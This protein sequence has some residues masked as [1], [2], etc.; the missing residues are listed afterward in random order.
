MPN[1]GESKYARINESE[2]DVFNEL[3][4]LLRQVHLSSFRGNNHYQYTRTLLRIFEPKYKYVITLEDMRQAMIMTIEFAVYVSV[5]HSHYATVDLLAAKFNESR[6]LT[7]VCCLSYDKAVNR[8]FFV[9]RFIDITDERVDRIPHQIRI[10]EEKFKLAYRQQNSAAKAIQRGWRK[11]SSDCHA[12]C[13]D[14][15][16][17]CERL[18][19][20]QNPDRFNIHTYWIGQTYIYIQIGKDGHADERGEQVVD[21]GY[22][23]IYIR[24]PNSESIAYELNYGNEQT[25]KNRSNKVHTQY[26][27][28][29]IPARAYICT[30]RGVSYRKIE[31]V[32]RLGRIYRLDGRHE[33]LLLQ[34]IRE[35]TAFFSTQPYGYGLHYECNTFVL[36]SLLRLEMMMQGDAAAPTPSEQA[37][38]ARA[39]NIRD[40]AARDQTARRLSARERKKPCGDSGCNIM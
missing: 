19:V 37:T 33:L 20:K 4:D 25:A 29:R 28:P 23:V 15:E 5:S 27:N 10:W 9:T 17:V 8:E 13:S 26:R 3:L 12:T 18:G 11:F 16:S 31:H 21:R 38:A 1:L 24:K 6:I 30:H 7:S 34:A 35:E 39:Q 40:Q 22:A 2:F 36:R 14:L 32:S